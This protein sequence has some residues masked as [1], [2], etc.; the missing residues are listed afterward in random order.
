MKKLTSRQK[1]ERIVTRI[2]NRIKMIES[3][4]GSYLTKRACYRYYSQRSEEDK[5][6]REIKEKEKQLEELKH[7]VKH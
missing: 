6:K 5:I 1:E 4:Y 7:K 2:I 3:N